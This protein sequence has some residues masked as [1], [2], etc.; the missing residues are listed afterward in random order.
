MLLGGLEG[1]EVGASAR[2]GGSRFAGVP[3]VHVF[4]TWQVG[5]RLQTRA[6]MTKMTIRTPNPE[7]KEEQEGQSEGEVVQGG[8]R[9]DRIWRCFWRQW[10]P[11]MVVPRFGSHQGRLLPQ[12]KQAGLW[13]AE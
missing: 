5:V 3:I 7:G 11:S 4:S 9:R 2:E 10:R 8:L 6:P 1:E 12:F 13:R